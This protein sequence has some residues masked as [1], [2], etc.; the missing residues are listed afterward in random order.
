VLLRLNSKAVVAGIILLLEATGLT[1][2][3]SKD[4]SVAPLPVC[5]SPHMQPRTGWHVL[6]DADD[7]IVVAAPSS[8]TTYDRGVVYMHGGSA[9]RSEEA[10]VELSYGY[11]GLDSF[12]NRSKACRTEIDGIPTVYIEER[13]NTGVS[14]VAWYQKG[15]GKDTPGMQPVLSASSSQAADL[16]LLRSIL[17]SVRRPLKRDQKGAP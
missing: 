13:S 9:W 16:D 11:W 10:V 2:G 1:S 7:S 8:F 15:Y 6:T 4:S 12:A 17:W 14:L 5:T 3:T